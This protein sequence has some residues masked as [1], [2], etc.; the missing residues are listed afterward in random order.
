MEDIDPKRVLLP[1]QEHGNDIL[2]RVLEGDT[3]A[4][5]FAKGKNHELEKIPVNSH[6]TFGF[7]L[8]VLLPRPLVRQIRG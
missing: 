3:R 6:A 2:A 7:K 1:K 8:S 4:T 5:Y